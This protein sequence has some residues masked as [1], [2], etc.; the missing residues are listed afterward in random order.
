MV[1]WLSELE[2]EYVLTP[3]TPKKMKLDLSINTQDIK[4]SFEKISEDIMN[5]WVLISGYNKYRICEIEFYFNATGIHDDNYTHS[6]ELQKTSGKWY[7][8]PSGID[9]TFG[10]A[11]CYGGI[12]IRALDNLT[13][14]KEDPKRYTYGP[15]NCLQEI[16]RNLDSAYKHDYTF[17]LEETIADLIEFEKP[18]AAPRVGLNKIRNE[19]MY[20]KL[21]RFLVLPKKK[22]AEKTKI[23]NAMIKQGFSEEKANEIWG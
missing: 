14:T 18:I 12:L 19:E 22:H 15:L 11:E 10:N 20:D 23:V 6:H 1:I 2:S 16:F 3:S 17:G 8:H 9:I 21:Y 5:S 7:L 13:L 4:G